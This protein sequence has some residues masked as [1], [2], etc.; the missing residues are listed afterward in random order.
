[1]EVSVRL[2]Y[3]NRTEQHSD[4]GEW[5]KLDEFDRVPASWGVYPLKIESGFLKGA[6]PHNASI[7]LLYA[8]Q[9]SADKNQT[10]HWVPVILDKYRRPAYEEHSKWEHDDLVIA[11]PATFG[12]IALLLIGGCLWNRKTRRIQLGNVMSR[13]RHGLKSGRKG[14]GG[15]RGRGIQLDDQT[16]R[17]LYEYR[18]DM[19]PEEPVRPRQRSASDLSDLMG[20]PTSPAVPPQQGQGNAPNTFRDELDRQRQERQRGDMF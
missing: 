14:G 12:G 6:Y 20:I 3:F 2:D 1:M 9:G 18:D 5:Q 16:G 15:R 13:A 8:V 17:P 7:N 10:E 19:G 4:D 11:L